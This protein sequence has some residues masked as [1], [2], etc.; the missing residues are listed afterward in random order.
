MPLKLGDWKLN[1]NGNQG[2][3]KIYGVDVNGVVSGSY[4]DDIFKDTLIGGIWDEASRTLHYALAYPAQQPQQ[5]DPYKVFSIFFKGV[6]F[7]T[8]HHAA[9]GQDILWTLVGFVYIIKPPPITVFDWNARRNVFGWFAQI[10]EV[11]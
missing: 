1:V 10:T 5:Q 4:T 11:A 6:L 8:P 3:L 9:L 7:G 2:I